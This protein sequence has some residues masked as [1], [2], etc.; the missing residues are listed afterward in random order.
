MAANS[1]TE[2]HDVSHA[3]DHSTHGSGEASCCGG[4]TGPAGAIPSTPPEHGRSFQVSGLDCVEEVS[5][6][7]KVVGPK[8]G[9]AQH[10]AFDVINGRMTGILPAE[11]V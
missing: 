11:A 8:L 5:I 6:L 7:S 10:L 1:E 4:G 3:H 9:G 2:Q